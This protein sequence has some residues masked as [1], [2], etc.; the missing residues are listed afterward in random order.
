MF[1]LY[2]RWLGLSVHRAFLARGFT[3]RGDVIAALYAAGRIRYRREEASIEVWIDPRLVSGRPHASGFTCVE[4]RRPPRSPPRHPRPEG[5]DAWILDPTLA[6]D[7]SLLLAKGRYLD[8]LASD[9]LG[10]AAGVP[11]SR[12][13]PRRAWA[14][15]PSS[16][17]T[18]ASSTPPPAAATSASSRPPRDPATPRFAPS[19]TTSSPG[20]WRGRL[21]P[22]ADRGPLRHSA[23]SWS[24]PR[25]TGS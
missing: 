20:P 18:P 22:G 15:H 1:H 7:E 8:V 13:P 11:T 19:S 16:P 12:R 17:R 4:G 21:G 2:Q 25:R 5:P 14:C 23:S 9:A 24:I 10:L 6:T 3:A